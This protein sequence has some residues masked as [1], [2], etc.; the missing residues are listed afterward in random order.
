MYEDSELGWNME[1]R[2]RSRGL[3]GLALILSAG[4]GFWYLFW[5]N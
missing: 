4:V 2:K 3:V 5:N 1:R